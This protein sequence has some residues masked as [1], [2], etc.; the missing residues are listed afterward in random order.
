MSTTST[1]T[2]DRGEPPPV[3][4]SAVQRIVPAIAGLG[5][6]AVLTI[7]GTQGLAQPPPTA[8][9]QISVTETRLTADDGPSTLGTRGPVDLVFTVRNSYAFPVRITA[10]DLAPTL[11]RSC[12]T[13]LALD[14]AATRGNREIPPGQSVVVELRAA[15]HV[16]GPACTNPPDALRVSVTVGQAG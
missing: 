6:A 7:N 12:Q 14:P 1:A 5:F 10:V 9:S 11:S 4:H 3:W 13:R 15:V 16:T 8:A 2:R